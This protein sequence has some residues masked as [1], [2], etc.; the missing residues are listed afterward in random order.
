MLQHGSDLS[1]RPGEPLGLGKRDLHAGY[2]QKI[3]RTPALQGI[4]LVPQ[5]RGQ[6]HGIA[7]LR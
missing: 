5:S 4:D 2:A 1:D 6:G 7:V 3:L